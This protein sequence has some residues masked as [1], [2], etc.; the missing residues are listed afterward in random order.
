MINIKNFDSNLLKIDKESYENVDIYYIG[1]IAIKK[2]DDY[3]NICSVNPL[4]LIVNAANGYTEEE[5][6]SKYLVLDSTDKNKE[7]LKKYTELWDEIKNLIKRI[8]GG[9]EGKYKNNF[10]KIKFSSDDNLPLGRI[11]KLSMLTIA[12][13]S[14]FEEDSKY[15]LQI[16]LGEYLYNTM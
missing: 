9:K 1:Y 10:M 14:V 8:N 5:N 12:V 16:F 15:Y 3:E 2:I 6:G 4:Y 11:L 7:V 13:R